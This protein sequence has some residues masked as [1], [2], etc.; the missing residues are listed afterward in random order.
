M[1]AEDVRQSYVQSPS[2]AP[3]I[4]DKQEGDV[5]STSGLRIVT[6]EFEQPFLAQAPMEPMN[7]TRAHPRRRSRGVDRDPECEHDPK[8]R[9]ASGEPEP[10][11]VRVNTTL[12]GRRFWPSRHDGVC[13]TSRRG[14]QG[15]RR[16]VKLVY[17]REDDMK[18]GYYRPQSRIRMTAGL[19][20]EGKDGAAVGEDRRSGDFQ[21]DGLFVSAQIQRGRRLCDCSAWAPPYAIANLRVEW[22]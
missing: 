10:E 22:G 21:V 3:G 5:S 8:N 15:D 1:S 16:P 4:V 17:T 18:G 9:C 13:P 2:I 20:A 14:G 11:Q 12:P 7:C 6:R 19:D